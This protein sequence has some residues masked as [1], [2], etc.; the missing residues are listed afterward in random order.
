MLKQPNSRVAIIS[1]GLQ[2]VKVI[3]EAEGIQGMLSRVGK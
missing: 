1:D 2:A 3:R